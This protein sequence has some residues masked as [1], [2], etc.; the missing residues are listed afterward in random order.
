[1]DD[2][3]IMDT[4]LVSECDMNLFIEN[5]NKWI[6]YMQDKGDIVEVQYQLA[7]IHSAFIIGRR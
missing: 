1:M 5:V 7:G 6:N 4:A 3:T 2:K